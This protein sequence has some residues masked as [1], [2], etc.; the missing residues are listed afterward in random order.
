MADE[1]AAE[2]LTFAQMKA[3]ANR[4]SDALRKSDSLRLLLEAL[5]TEQEA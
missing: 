3:I 1:F 2:N 5:E 4:Y